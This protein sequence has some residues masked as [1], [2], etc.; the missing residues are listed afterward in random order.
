MKVLLSRPWNRTSMLIPN[1]GLGYLSS[2]LQRTGHDV[3][4]LDCIRDRVNPATFRRYV[5][6]NAF[7]IVGFQV[8]TFDLPSLTTYID[9]IHDIR[10]IRIA[11]GPHPTAVPREFMDAFPCFDYLF[12]G[13]AE[14][15]LPQL[16]NCLNSSHVSMD[17]LSKIPGLCFRSPTGLVINPSY[18]HDN[19]DEFGFPDWEQISPLDYP[20]AP[21]GT[22]TRALPVA[23]ITVT[24]GC[25]FPCTFCAGKQ[26]S[27]RKIRARS[28]AHVIQELKFLTE[29]FHIREFHIQDDNF[30]FSKQYL[31]DFCH[32]LLN[33]GLI[34]HW[35]CPNGIRLDTLDEEMLRAMSQAG[36]YSV[37]VGIEAG[38]QRV[39]DLMK[40]RTSLVDVID[41]VNLIRRIT[42]WSITGFFIL[43]YPGETRD[44][45]EATIR[46]SRRLPIDKANFGIL[47]PLPGTE[48]T[49][50]AIEMGWEPEGNQERMSEYRSDF[51]PNGMS[52]RQFR[53]LFRRA[54]IGFYC[55]P[56]IILKFLLEIKSR[57]QLNVLF[58]RFLDVVIS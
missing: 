5:Q 58:R 35:A 24:R 36:C 28:I 42:N 50:A 44:E 54:F 33:S 49:L 18:F 1:H 6:D 10:I 20:I 9:A 21:Q 43:G 37:A 2:A 14:I 12:A 45:M 16:I 52:S 53:W 11:G 32:E 22:F 57:D 25:P 23:P 46:L 47:M 30:T 48:A 40:K 38:S 19:L 8:Y 55:R 29:R 41:R 3:R 26:T 51:L 17:V 31:L 56:R 27:G 13:E 39:L 15:G 7:D 34:L 4:I